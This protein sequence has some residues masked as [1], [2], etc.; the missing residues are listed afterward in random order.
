[1]TILSHVLSR[2]SICAAAG[3]AAGTAMLSLGS[4]PAT[5]SAAKIAQ[6]PYVGRWSVS[7]ATPKFSAR[8]LAYKTIDISRCGTSL[9]GVSVTDSGKCG[10]SL[11]RMKHENADGDS[12]MQGHANWG[13]AKKNIVVYSY[14]GPPENAEEAN[15]FGFELYVGDGYDMGGRSENMPKFYAP[16]KRKGA[17]A[18]HMK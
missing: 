1:M 10:A 3:V 6:N 7:E 9:C 5:A 8:G 14:G 4:V 16:Y 17:S 18:C 2:L 12:R 11:F 15:N 13:K